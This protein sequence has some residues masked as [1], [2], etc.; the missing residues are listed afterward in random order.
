[1]MS[2]FLFSFFPVLWTEREI[3][4]VRIIVYRILFKPEKVSVKR[5]FC[6]MSGR[7]LQCSVTVR[8]K[9]GASGFLA[10]SGCQTVKLIQ[11]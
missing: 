8:D 1:M 10:S 3:N 11:D 7:T 4:S 9:A 6:M 5:F 2:R